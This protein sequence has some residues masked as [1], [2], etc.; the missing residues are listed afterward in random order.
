M[1]DTSDSIVVDTTKR[2]FRDLCDPQTVNAAQDDAW[3]GKLWNA[4]EENGLTLAWIPEDRGGVGASMADGFD[5]IRVAGQY[6]EPI[7]LSET[8]LAGWLLAR[9]GQQI[10]A[11]GPV[12]VAPMRYDE[13]ISLHD[14]KLSGSARAVAYAKGAKHIAVFAQNGDGNVIAMVSPGHCKLAD[15]GTNMGGE[16]FDVDFNGV[17]PDSVHDLPGWLTRDTFNWLGAAVRASQMTG[18]LETILAISTQYAQEREAFGRTI[19]KFQAVQH[20]LAELGGEVAAALAAAGSAADTVDKESDNH[21]ALFLEI[22][23]AKIR[24]GEAVNRG[25]TIAHQVHGAIGYTGE[26]I[27]QRFTRRM[28]GWRDDFG[29]ESEWAVE[30]GN[31]VA[32]EGADELWPKLATR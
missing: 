6:A 25:A 13:T 27:L 2:I 1:T 22:A 16:R 14:G 4:L 28:W 29:N 18:A 12:T 10:E 32:R 15:R 3:K 23:S 21:D 31:M 7:A 26:H 11:N 9:A 20:N 5:V 19:S 8:L 17:T 30:L 24:I